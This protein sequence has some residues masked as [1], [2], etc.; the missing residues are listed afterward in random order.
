MLVTRA[1]MPLLTRSA[2][3]V[4]SSMFPSAPV[5]PRKAIIKAA[6]GKEP[7]PQA[8]NRANATGHDKA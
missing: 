3:Q 8:A 7:V 4:F 1:S 6:A 5:H 2:R